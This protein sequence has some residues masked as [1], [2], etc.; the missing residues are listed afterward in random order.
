MSISNGDIEVDDQVRLRSATGFK[1]RGL[2]EDRTY[3]VKGIPSRS[4]SSG[5]HWTLVGEQ[6]GKLYIITEPLILEVLTP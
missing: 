5:V 6:S 4:P 2:W 1:T 3:I